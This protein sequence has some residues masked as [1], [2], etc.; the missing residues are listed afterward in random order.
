MF[1]AGQ[2]RP[3]TMAAV[4]GLEEPVLLGVLERIEGTVVAANWNSPGQVVISGDVPSVHAAMEACRQAGAKRVI[5]LEVSGAFHSPLMESA[6]AGLRE[7]LAS[8]EIRPPQVPV[9]TNVS[10]RP[11][12]DVEEIRRGLAGQLTSAVRWEE[13][14]RNLR[15][16]GVERFL[17]LGPGKVLSGLARNIDRGAATMA[18]G[19]PEEIAAFTA[20]SGVSP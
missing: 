4:M 16:A 19:R 7:A 9:T 15:G 6:A 20:Q 12:T 5:A 8:V 13:T 11:L 1:R 18:I 17:E 14:I 10:A 3:G 2:E